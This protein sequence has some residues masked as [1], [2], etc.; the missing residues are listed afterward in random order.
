[1]V[2]ER[3]AGTVAKSALEA[4]MNSIDAGATRIE[5]ELTPKRLVIRDNG[6]GFKSEKEIDDYFAVFGQP[7]E[8]D[9]DGRSVDAKYGTYL[10]CCFALSAARTRAFKPASPIPNCLRNSLIVRP[11]SHSSI[12]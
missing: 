9:G 1:M 7:H 2:I 10:Y 4:V 3:Q 12:T 6:K 11:F 8:L 5:V